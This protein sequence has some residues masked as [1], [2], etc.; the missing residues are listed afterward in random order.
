MADRAIGKVCSNDGTLVACAGNHEDEVLIGTCSYCKGTVT[1]ENYNIVNGTY[2]KVVAPA[3]S[4]ALKASDVQEAI[5]IAAEPVLNPE[6]EPE[7]EAPV[8]IPVLDESEVMY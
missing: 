2:V 1:A 8:D 4:D 6:P 7:P 3:G 5:A